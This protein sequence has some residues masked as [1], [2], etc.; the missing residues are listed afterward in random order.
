MP[1][2]MQN[3]NILLAPLFFAATVYMALGR[4]ITAINGEAY[5]VVPLKWLTRLFVC[6]DVLTLAVQASGAGIMI[7]SSLAKT[8]QAI[9]IVGLLA[10]IIIFGFFCITTVLFHRRMAR[11][12]NWSG[13]EVL[14]ASGGQQ[15]LQAL[16]GIS[17]CI[18]GRSIFRTAEFIDGASGYL[19]SVEWP[20]YIFDTLP[21]LCVVGLFW[22]T[23]PVFVGGSPG[24]RPIP[25][26][27]VTSEPLGR[28]SMSTWNR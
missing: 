21:M 25:L 10:Q 28:R 18:M 2:V 15:G 17:A 13:K 12:G 27:F 6:G 23:W 19:F 4:L 5:S 11:G 1:Y 14:L 9:A 3:N 7:V 8:G 16:Y 24:I 22:W 26:Q 20:L